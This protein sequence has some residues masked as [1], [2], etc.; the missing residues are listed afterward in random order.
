MG[1]EATQAKAAAACL[2]FHHGWQVS[3]WAIYVAMGASVCADAREA[4]SFSP[5]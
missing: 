4:A 1:L 3:S 2:G 5:F